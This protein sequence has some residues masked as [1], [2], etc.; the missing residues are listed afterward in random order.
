[1][2]RTLSLVSGSES[3]LKVAV[4][5]SF[6]KNDR[7][8][9]SSPLALEYVFGGYNKKHIDGDLTTIPVDKSKGY[10][11]INIDRLNIGLFHQ[12]GSLEGIVDTGTTLLILPNA[13]A[14]KVAKAYGATDN[15][16]G[17]FTIGK[18]IYPYIGP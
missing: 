14:A 2:S 15:Y 8:H 6:L 17:T 11:G 12:F 10:W 7:N 3:P 18:F 4:V 13:I 5:V 16:D 9:L 1:M